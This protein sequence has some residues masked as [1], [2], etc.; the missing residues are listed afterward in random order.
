MRKVR[1]RLGLVALVLTIL[2]VQGAPVFAQAGMTR[3]EITRIESPT[4]DGGSFGTVGQYE[5]LV[6]D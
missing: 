3:I 5:K 4:F 6:G 2:A 1:K